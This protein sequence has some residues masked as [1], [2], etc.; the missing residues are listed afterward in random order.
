[1]KIRTAFGAQYAEIPSQRFPAVKLTGNEPP[2]TGRSRCS[3]FPGGSPAC[4]PRG[5]RE[6][7]LAVAARGPG[8]PVLALPT[9]TL[10]S[11]GVVSLHREVL[12]SRNQLTLG[13]V[14][15]L[16]G[17]A[18]LYRNEYN[19]PAKK[20]AKPFLGISSFSP[21]SEIM[22]HDKAYLIKTLGTFPTW[23]QVRLLLPGQGV[24]KSQPRRLPQRK[25][26]G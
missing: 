15:P 4:S 7:R 1:M 6:G 23:E 16:V 24:F 11:T 3:C 12:V 25:T 19:S 26:Q 10:P 18:R 2:G 8:P 21:Y 5:Q 20:S 22:K 17:K 9:L 14:V 13:G